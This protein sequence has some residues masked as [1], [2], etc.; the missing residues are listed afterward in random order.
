MPD[1]IELRAAQ[2]SDQ[3]VIRRMVRQARINPFGLK[4][5]NFLVC[6]MDGRVVGIGQV[7][8][9]GDGSRELASIAVHPDCRRLGIATAII[10][11]LLAGEEGILYLTC[12]RQ[13]ES[14]YQPFGFQQVTGSELS[15][16]MA[17]LDRLNQWFG[18]IASLFTSKPLSG[19]IMR[20]ES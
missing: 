11:A 2:A 19:I 6:E 4:W 15:G 17:R 10:E 12:R 3:K 13:M 5:P 16:T 18:R 7:K 14:F 9:H 20:R 8:S 1:P